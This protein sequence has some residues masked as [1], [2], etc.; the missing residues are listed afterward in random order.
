M[1]KTNHATTSEWRTAPGHT[2][3]MLGLATIATRRAVVPVVTRM[4]GFDPRRWI[5]R[6]TPGEPSA[7][8]PTNWLA[9]HDHID[10]VAFLTGGGASPTDGAFHEMDDDDDL[11][12]R[13]AA[14]RRAHEMAAGSGRPEDASIFDM[15]VVRCFK[16]VQVDADSRPVN[17]PTLRLLASSRI[18]RH[19]R[20]MI[21][22][23]SE[24]LRKLR[25]D[26]DGVIRAQA[27][28]L[29]G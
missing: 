11:H 5:T 18:Y 6:A 23:R 24:R 20:E 16:A 21:P 1:T 12:D 25:D 10:A 19:Y 7:E 26:A 13:W 17:V 15:M 4:S 28:R 29:A 8:E 2:G 9:G 27:A 3:E 22:T 14:L